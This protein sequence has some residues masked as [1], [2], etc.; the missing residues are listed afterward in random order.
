MAALLPPL[1]LTGATVLRDGAMTRRTVAISGGRIAA[2]PFPAVDMTGYVVL[3]GIVD[4]GGDHLRP[5]LSHAPADEALHSAAA[6]AAR[7]G[8]TTAWATQLWSLDD[9]S[10]GF[11]ATEDLMNTWSAANAGPID[12]RLHLVC[13]V[14]AT[15]EPERLLTVV[16]RSGVDLV[17]FSDNLASR[18]ALADTT[19]ESFR[20]WAAER[21]QNPASL[22]E[23]IRAAETRR[24]EIPRRLCRLA[25]AFD[26]LGVTYGSRGDIDGETRETY[27]MLGAKL[28]VAPR[29]HAAAAVAQAVGD[30][31]LM[32]A[33]TVLPGW[34]GTLSARALLKSRKCQALI[35]GDYPGTLLRAAL[36]LSDGDVNRLAS[37][38]PLISEK[39]AEI[40][41]LP[42]RGIIEPG[43]RADLTILN[44]ATSRIEATICEGRIAYLAGRAATRFYTAGMSFEDTTPENKGY[45]GAI[46]LRA[47]AI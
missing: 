32:P 8:I 3:P 30:P 10:S 17:S 12:L 23:R 6:D 37:V 22:L 7:V 19:P 25:E 27:A 11:A 42:D 40:M 39:P 18:L 16:R 9:G 2:G 28:C 13:E 35:S 15:S 31:V 43:K 1:R 41:G 4:L 33:A 44:P 36:T 46:P 24:S 14:L 26:R 20:L 21:G 29:S 47:R 5:H 45:N 38:W 34:S